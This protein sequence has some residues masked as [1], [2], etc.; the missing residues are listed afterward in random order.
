MNNVFITRFKDIPGKNGHLTPIEEKWDVP[1][2]IKRIFYIYDVPEN[3]SRGHHAHETLYETLICLNG[4]VNVKLKNPIEEEIYKLDNP[5]VGLTIGP[6]IWNEMY[7]FS[8]DC[9]LLVLC[10]DRYIEEDNIR[11]YEDYLIKVGSRF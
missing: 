2:E 10:S 4:S 1:Y 3:E 5:K 9:V 11:N 8:E 7:N 6:W